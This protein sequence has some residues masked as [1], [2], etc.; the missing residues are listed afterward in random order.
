MKKFHFNVSVLP[1]QIV[2]EYSVSAALLGKNKSSNT[3]TEWF[4]SIVQ[5]HPSADWVWVVSMIT[6][7]VHLISAC[8]VL[9]YSSQ[10]TKLSVAQTAPYIMASC[11]NGT[12]ADDAPIF[13]TKLDILGSTRKTYLTVLVVVFFLLSA[14]FQLYDV[15]FRDKYIER[16]KANRVCEVRYAEYSLSAS[17]MMVAI[18]CTLQIYDIFTHVLL[19]TCTAL[20][21][22]CGYIADSIRTHE[23]FLQMEWKSVDL[24]KTICSLTAVHLRELHKLKWF[25]HR[26]GWLAI[27][28]PFVV[29]LWS[30]N[31]TIHQ[32]GCDAE[33][34]LGRDETPLPVFVYFIVISQFMLFCSFGLVQILSFRGMCDT[35]NPQR[36]IGVL[37]E[38][39]YVV[40]SLT[41]KS[42]L[43]WV[44]FANIILVS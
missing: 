44:I 28:P 20:C 36:S 34:V 43:G 19:F 31:R 13:T 5:A 9:I 18:A 10:D 16:I 17:I 30:F 41:A 37:T 14:M 2:D 7:F 35:E 40:L 23:E 24:P 12:S 21:M 25:T 11:F 22:L 33:A 8:I 42:V 29:I 32:I 38:F 26:V 3:Y 1:P 39:R 15:S 6:A 4:Y 27:T